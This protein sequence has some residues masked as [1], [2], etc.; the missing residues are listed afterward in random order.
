MKVT[1]IKGFSDILPGEVEIWQAVEAKA[2]QIFKAY[3]FSEIRIPVLEKTELFNR[4]IGETTDI[5]EKEM[6]TFEDR[7]SRGAESTETTNLTL[8]PE[9]TAGVVRAY[10]E[11]EMYKTEPVRKLYYMGPM[12][13]RERPQ[14]GR[15]RQFHQIGAEALGR[16][17]PFIDAEILLLLNDFFGALGLTEPFLQINSLGCSECRPNY[18]QAL[19][20][21]LKERQELLCD[22]CRRRIDRNPLRALDCKEPGCIRVTKDAP[23]ILDWLCANCREHFQTV[24]RLLQETQVQFTL[25][26]RMVRGLDYYCRTT[27]EWTTTQLG[28]QGAIAAGGRYDGL[29]QELGGP[30]I[31]GV[32]FAMG[33]ERLTMLLRMQETMVAHGPSCYVAW[34]GETARDW[35]FPLVHRLR[36]KGYSVEMEG[37]ARSLKS[38]MRRADKLKAASVLIV[39]DDELAKGKAVWRNMAS[40]QQEEI[41]LDGIETELMTKK[42]G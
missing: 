42:A 31:A 27:F 21:F 34:V 18:R 9:G 15:M 13:R 1:A 26:P 22:N 24:Q 33:V 36:Q 29:V 11:S 3:N 32:G 10:V 5:V 39:G 2:H 14:K 6:Y 17:D 23:S 40:K 30:A 7:D 28:S 20:A 16:G 19:L 35:A 38:Q 41:G 12:F 37:E 8:R 25:N 4:S